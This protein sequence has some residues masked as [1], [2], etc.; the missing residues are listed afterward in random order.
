MFGN[1]VKNIDLPSFI[2]EIFCMEYIEIFMECNQKLYFDGMMG[3][4]C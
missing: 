1:K 2:N 3:N 4:K